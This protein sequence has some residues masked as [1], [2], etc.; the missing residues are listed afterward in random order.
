V[1][2]GIIIKHHDYT[3]SSQET[4]ALQF[5]PPIPL[6]L[7]L[8]Q[9]NGL[10][11][12]ESIA[13]RGEVILHGLMLIGESLHLLIREGEGE[14]WIPHI[15]CWWYYYNYHHRLLLLL[16]LLLLPLLLLLRRRRPP[17]HFVQYDEKA[18]GN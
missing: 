11:I 10:R 6:P 5:T 14:K 3:C 13:E 9:C 4:K 2:C 7:P 18:K 8:T 12:L 1:A 17:H 15:W 16:L